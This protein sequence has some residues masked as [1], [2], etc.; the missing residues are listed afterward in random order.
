MAGDGY[1]T[2]ASLRF[3]EELRRHNE[4]DWFLKNKERYERT[5]RDPMLHFIG[6]IGP[7]LRKIDPAFVADPR[8]AGGSMMRIYRDTRFSRD[9][10]PY[11]TFA[12]A[13][14]RHAKGKD[15]FSPGYYLHIEPGHSMVGAGIWRPDAE[16]L[17]KIR[18]AILADPKRWRRVT[19]GREF[20]SSCG[21]AG[22]SLKRAPLG[23]DP[24]H[25]LI[26]E[27]K[28]KDFA[29]SSAL[30]DHQVCGPDLMAAV[31]GALRTTA[32]FVRF[33][34]KAVGLL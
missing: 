5:V 12:A 28:R 26:D 13:H 6:D 16:T 1:F 30:D 27:L 18:D 4:R 15:G 29:A 7:A 10:S 33:L 19:S 34:E 3:L 23:Y 17:K 11:K 25:P 21:M 2:A 14:F 8:P 24:N 9:K 32:P 22:E 31:T 20:R